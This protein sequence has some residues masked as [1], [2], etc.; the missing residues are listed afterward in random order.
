MVS[1]A[2]QVL[3]QSPRISSSGASPRGQSHTD[4]TGEHCSDALGPW[5][6]FSSHIGCSS[7]PSMEAENTGILS[8]M[9]KSGPQ[10][11]GLGAG[12]P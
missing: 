9:G 5:V 1:T 4:G 7:T 12:Q 3:R 10:G 8:L 6:T 11:E 2:F